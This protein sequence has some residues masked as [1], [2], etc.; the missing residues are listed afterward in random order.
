MMRGKRL[1][2]MNGMNTI[3]TITGYDRMNG[4]TPFLGEDRGRGWVF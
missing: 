4:I 3:D 1:D 2:G